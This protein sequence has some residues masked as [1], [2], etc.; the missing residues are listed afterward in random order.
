LSISDRNALVWLIQAADLPSGKIDAFF[1][2]PVVENQPREILPIGLSTINDT[3]M[4]QLEVLGQTSAVDPPKKTDTVIT[5]GTE[6]TD[7]LKKESKEVKE[8]KEKENE[9][10]KETKPAAGKPIARTVS[11]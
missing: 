6:K 1:P 10:E 7:E 4:V 8:Q 3:K 11:V 9:T 2:N 5:S